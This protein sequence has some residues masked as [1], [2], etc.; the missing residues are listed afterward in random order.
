MLYD[1]FVDHRAVEHRGKQDRD[2]VGHLPLK[3]RCAKL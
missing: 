2:L 3:T 1:S